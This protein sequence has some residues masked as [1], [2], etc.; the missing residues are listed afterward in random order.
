MVNTARSP[1]TTSIYIYI[2]Q[3]GRRK[4]LAVGVGQTSVDQQER[5]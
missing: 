1:Y 2:S 4:A 3:S 5:D